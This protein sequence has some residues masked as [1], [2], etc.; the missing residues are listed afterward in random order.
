MGSG[1]ILNNVLAEV[2][3]NLKDPYTI[4]YGNVYRKDLNRIYDGRFSPFKF[5]VVNISH[6]AIFYP[7]KAF[8]KYQYNLHYRMQADHALNMNLYGDKQYS[9]K[10]I[11]KNN[12]PL[13][14]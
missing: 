8:R 2:E 6:Q 12:L 14:G 5:A 4:Y 3:P 13:P 11:N 10:F 7:S 9:F 1:D